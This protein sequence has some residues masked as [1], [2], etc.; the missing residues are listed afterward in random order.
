MTLDEWG[1]SLPSSGPRERQASWEHAFQC[2]YNNRF[3]R[4]SDS[5]VGV[6]LVSREVGG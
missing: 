3:C 2:R 6:R 4:S 1:P 5:L